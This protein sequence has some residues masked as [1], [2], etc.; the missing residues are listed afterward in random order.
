MFAV[1]MA[2]GQGTR[3]WPKSRRSKPKQFLDIIGNKTMVM[4][5]IE[6]LTPLIPREN[7]YAVVNESHL[8]ETI[9][10]TGLSDNIIMEP[11]G[12]NTA[13]CIGLAALYIQRKDPE[14]VMVALPADHHIEDQEAFL[15]TLLAAEDVARSTGYL[16]TLGTEPGY[17]ATGFG[18]IEKG[19]LLGK[20]GSKEFFKVKRFTEK[21][22]ITTATEFL[23]DGNFFWNSGIFVWK[24][25]AI[26]K[27]IE[28]HLPFL[29]NG[30]TKIRGAIGTDREREAISKVYS[31]IESISIDYGVMEKS[32]ITAVVPSD[33][34]WN[35]VG[36]WA[37]L[38]EV[39]PKDE[40][41]NILIGKCISLETRDTVVYGK[42]KLIAT[43]GLDGI[44]VVDTGDAILISRKD[45][46]QDV[47]KIVERLEKEG[48]DEYL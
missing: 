11:V 22:D 12:R 23:A 6:R 34:G 40:D 9:E 26:L 10:Q 5:T 31:S 28:T 7:I 41:E 20:S 48:M 47:K 38:D 14:G 35:D 45:K 39:L 4:K 37:S 27:Q 15:K 29:Y 36:S 18:Y 2:G 42:D 1:V 17:P 30:L 46:C 43:L 19:D 32:N 25:P 16:V 33:F 3:F 13:P 21:P 24:V 8:Q 44:V